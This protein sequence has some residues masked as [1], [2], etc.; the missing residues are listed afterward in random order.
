MDSTP[1]YQ[2]LRVAASCL[3][4]SLLVLLGLG[5]WAG[6][7][8]PLG[9]GEATVS[10]RST[11]PDDRPTIPR[12]DLRDTLGTL[13]QVGGQ[14]EAPATVVVFLSQTCPISRSYVPML[15]RLHRA[16]ASR[17]VRDNGRASPATATPFWMATK[18]APGSSSVQPT[19]VPA[20]PV[21]IPMGTDGWTTR[22]SPRAPTP[23]IPCTMRI[24]VAVVI[25]VVVVVTVLQ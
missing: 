10:V 20:R 11:R 25:V 18:R 8:V 5:A 14:S 19:P 7:F 23:T 2:P 1:P 13:H 24:E 15:G 22:R 12:C 17:R 4:V 6:G 3:V 9:L 21:P 16:A